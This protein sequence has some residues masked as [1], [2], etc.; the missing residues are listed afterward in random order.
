MGSVSS[1]KILICKNWQSQ[2]CT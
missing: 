1:N 2:V